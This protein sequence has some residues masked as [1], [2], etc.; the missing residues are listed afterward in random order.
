MYCPDWVKNLQPGD[1]FF[2]STM[3]FRGVVLL[4]DNNTLH[5]TWH[6]TINNSIYFSANMHYDDIGTSWIPYSSL[7]EELL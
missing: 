2:D 6:R 5:F 4:N 7:L 3:R 1:K